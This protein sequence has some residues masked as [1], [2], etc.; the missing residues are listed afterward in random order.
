MN[1]VDWDIT[2][3]HCIRSGGSCSPLR[4]TPRFGEVGR[5]MPLFLEEA[6]EAKVR[7]LAMFPS[8]R[9]IPGKTRQDFPA[10]LPVCSGDIAFGVWC[11]G[12]VDPGD[13]SGQLAR[14]SGRGQLDASANSRRMRR[15]VCFAKVPDTLRKPGSRHERSLLKML[16]QHPDVIIYWVDGL[17]G[18]GDDFEMKN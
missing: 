6:F 1:F 14:R 13:S 12:V 4:L 15:A 18:K 9:L 8:S 5:R 16:Y 3:L 11:V 7:R 10:G 2:D 17:K